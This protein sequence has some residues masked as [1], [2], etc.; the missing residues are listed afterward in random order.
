MA[1]KLIMPAYRFSWPSLLWWKDEEFNLFLNRFGEIRGQETDRRWMLYQLALMS[2]N[3][4]GDTA[5]C[6]VY[7]GAGSHLICKATQ[8][9]GQQRTHFIF[10][11]FQGISSPSNL[12]GNGYWRQGDLCCSLEQFKRPEGRISIHKGWIPEKFNDVKGRTFSFVH[13]DV[14]L[15]QPTSDSIA[16]FYPRLVPGGILVCDDYGFAT[17]PG[18][19]K[20]VDDF[21]ADKPERIFHLSCGSAFIIKS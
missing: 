16:F 21:M 1:G 18:A 14:D 19:K 4:A 15:Y 8:T 7:Q 6:G 13:V 12:D 9:N 11:S 3:I 20:A 10:D 5:E 2:V 17:C